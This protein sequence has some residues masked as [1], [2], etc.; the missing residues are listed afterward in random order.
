M[1]HGVTGEGRRSA[2]VGFVLVTVV[3]DV[4]ALGLVIPVLPKLVEQL[5]GSTARAAVIYGVFGTAWALMQLLFSPVLGALSDAYGRR[6]VLLLSS[7]GLGLDYILMALA[8]NLIWLFVG[9]VLS[10]ITAATFSTAGAYIADVTPAAER[11]GKFGLI[12]AAFGVGFVLG[13]ALGGLLG[14]QDP[15]LPFWVAAVL[16]LACASYGYFVLPESLPP[17]RRSPFRWRT[18]NP[19]G[20]LSLIRSKPGLSELSLGMFLYHVSHAVFPAVF[21]LHSGYRF[22]W[23]PGAVGAALAV[24]GVCSGVVQGGLVKPAV[25]RFGERRMLVFGMVAGIC[26]LGLM[27]FAP[28]EATFWLGM[29]IICLWGFIG[30]SA[31]GL[32]TRLVGQDQQGRLQGAGASLMGVA[33]LIGPSL[34]AGAFALGISGADGML[35]PGAPYLL[36]A[37]CLCLGMAVVLY[38]TRR[39]GALRGLGE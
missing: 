24:F 23:G 13:P 30:P 18:A 1:T 39:G 21:V 34:F 28:G 37:M 11:A 36:A 14:A 25:A 6:P 20:A 5:S 4:M 33:N 9:R 12:G 29:A 15:R 10:G 7:F 27:A 16:S 35:F 8:P 38:A 19:L 22:G 3:L 31:Q 32:M 17:D 2:A 26:G